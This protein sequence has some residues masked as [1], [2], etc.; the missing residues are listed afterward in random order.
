LSGST[1]DQALRARSEGEDRAAE[2]R[3]R[4]MDALWSCVAWVLAAI[5]LAGLAWS[6]FR[7]VLST[8]EP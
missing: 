1:S 8:G 6:V 7:L 4:R 2:A 3:E 5:S